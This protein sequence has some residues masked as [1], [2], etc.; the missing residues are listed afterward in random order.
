MT[1]LHVTVLICWKVVTYV[2]NSLLFNLFSSFNISFYLYPAQTLPICFYIFI[3]PSLF[4][5]STDALPANPLCHSLFLSSCLSLVFLKD[6]ETAS[7]A[8]VALGSAG[9]AQQWQ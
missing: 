9:Q 4:A 7:S 2:Y 8:V 1:V 5:G 3:V 6:A